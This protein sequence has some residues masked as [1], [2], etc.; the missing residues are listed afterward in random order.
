M[1]LEELEK[2]NNNI[3]STEKEVEENAAPIIPTIEP[4]N[5]ETHDL[6][7][8]VEAIKNGVGEPVVEAPIEEQAEESLVNSEALEK[9]FDLNKNSKLAEY[10]NDS[11][12]GNVDRQS[13][14]KFGEPSE[15]LYKEIVELRDKK[16]NKDIAEYATAAVEAMA[17]NQNVEEEKTKG[18]GGVAAF[19]QVWLISILTSVASVGIIVFGVAL[20]T[21]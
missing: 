14:K 18:L 6:T 11:F 10:I 12:D 19:S 13:V 21:R 17:N 8:A 2:M 9:E 3:E 4:I 7:S 15:K 20:L 16:K 5:A 1:N